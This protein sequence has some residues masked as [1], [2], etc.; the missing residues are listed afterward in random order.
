[1]YKQ[2]FTLI[3]LLVVVLIIGILTAIVVPIYTLA[4]EKSRASDALLNLSS[5]AKASEVYRLEHGS[6]PA[7][8]DWDKLS[9]SLEGGQFVYYSPIGGNAWVS[10]SAQ[11][12]YYLYG[13]RLWAN[14]GPSGSKYN[15]QYS[16]TDKQYYCQAYSSGSSFDFYN[17]VCQSLCG[18]NPQTTS[19]DRTECKM[20]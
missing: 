2:G 12:R 9:L 14:R 19:S 5:I 15:I 10:T 8:D 18:D 20:Q 7:A 11:W 6:Y 1:M 16:Y 3:E 17:K 4:V 13:T